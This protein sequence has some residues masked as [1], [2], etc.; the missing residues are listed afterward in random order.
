MQKCALP[1]ECF[2]LFEASN[3]SA[4]SRPGAANGA[5]Q[6]RM[7]IRKIQFRKQIS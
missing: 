6:G 4:A 1:F 7:L 3:N 5:H 2:P